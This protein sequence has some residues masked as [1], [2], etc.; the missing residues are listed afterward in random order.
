MGLATIVA[1]MDFKLF[2]ELVGGVVGAGV[3]WQRSSDKKVV[4]E[5]GGL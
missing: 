5:E 3:G 4:V 2:E 1:G